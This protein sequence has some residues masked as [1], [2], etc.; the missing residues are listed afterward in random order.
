MKEVDNKTQANQDELPTNKG[1]GDSVS[2]PKKKRKLVIISLIVLSFF[3]VLTGTILGY[4]FIKNK[5]VEEKKNQ[6]KST[7]SENNVVNDIKFEGVD[8]NKTKVPVAK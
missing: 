1:G 3:V 6:Q 5:Q 2:K 4:R 8:L 7:S